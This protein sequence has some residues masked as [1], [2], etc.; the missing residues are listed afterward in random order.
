MRIE[1]KDG[2]DEQF[3]DVSPPLDPVV[4]HEGMCIRGLRA[5]ETSRW[6]ISEFCFTTGDLNP[7]HLCDKD[8][9]RAGFPRVVAPGR[10]T[11][12]L[13]EGALFSY[14]IFLH[15]ILFESNETYENPVFPNDK[16]SF[17][18]LITSVRKTAKN[19]RQYVVRLQITGINQHD[20]IVVRGSRTLLVQRPQ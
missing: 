12:S 4:L 20:T 15:P 14:G 8:A 3:I 19:P 2:D 6:R 17:N 5:G 11:G 1:W 18:F 7:I 9:Q 13:I 16:I 10:F